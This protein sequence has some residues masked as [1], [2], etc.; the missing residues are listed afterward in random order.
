MESS[1]ARRFFTNM[2]CAL[3]VNKHRRKTLRAILNS[4]TIRHI[5]FIKRDLQM[6]LHRIKAFVGQQT[7]NLIIGVN[8]QYVY[9]FPLR[10]DNSRELALREKRIVDAFAGTSPILIPGV[11]LLD[12]DGHIVRK[13]DFIRGTTLRGLSAD[14][15]LQNI[16]RLA[17]QIAVFLDCIARQ[18]PPALRDLKYAPDAQP[19]FMFG[20]FQGDVC[21]N[22]L[23]DPETMDIVAFIDWEDS[24]FGD[25]SSIFYSEQRTP[26]KELMQAVE[27]EYRAIFAAH[28]K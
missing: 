5:R 16:D 1:K 2:I 3:V 19:G 28:N 6:P 13:Y 25:F 7:R 10:R 15:V 22:F 12:Y 11:E 8:N 23:V 21:D 9:K 20:W 18:D 26:R 4:P 17:H 24:M 14:D 27:R